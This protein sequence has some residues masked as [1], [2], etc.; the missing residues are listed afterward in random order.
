[1]T[2]RPLTDALTDAIERVVIEDS[3]LFTDVAVSSMGR[4]IVDGGALNLRL[5]ARDLAT[6]LV[7]DIDTAKLGRG[8]V[9]N[10]RL[11]QR[12]KR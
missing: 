8:R 5:A 6:E 9:T 10:R 12:L 1:M 4:L 7:R 2:T 3:R 11:D